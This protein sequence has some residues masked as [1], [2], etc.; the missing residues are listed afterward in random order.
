[1]WKY[2]KKITP[3]ILL[4]LAGAG[5]TIYLLFD[6]RYTGGAR[7]ALL[8]PFLLVTIVMILLD[9]ILRRA[10]KK[11]VLYLWLTEL[12]LFLLALYYFAVT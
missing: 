1:M 12:L 5:V 7:L 3:F 4:I 11:K 2:L 6:P 10:F 8:A 9:V